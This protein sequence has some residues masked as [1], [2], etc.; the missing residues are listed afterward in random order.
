MGNYTELVFKAEVKKDLPK[1]VLD[2]LNC[3]FNGA[4]D[5]PKPEVLPD[6]EFFKTERW[7][8]IGRGCSAYHVPWASSCFQEGHVFS[9]SDIKNYD[10]EIEKF[11]DWVT[12]YLKYCD[13]G[14]CIGYKWYCQDTEP[15]LIYVQ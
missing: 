7:H 6:H 15:E 12:P 8:L 14:D 10:S 3:L 13:V 11:I 4:S 2:I 5:I 1:E 9:R